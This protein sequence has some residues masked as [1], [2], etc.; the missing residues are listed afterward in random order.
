MPATDRSV[1]IAVPRETVPG[2]NRVALV[3]GS[4]R[5]LVRAG[6]EV[7]VQTGA[8]DR[9]YFQD[10][11]YEEAGARLMEEAGPL[12]GEADVVLKI[13]APTVTGGRHDRGGGR[14]AASSQ[15]LSGNVPPSGGVSVS[16]S[17]EA[18]LLKEGAVLVSFLYPDQ[19]PALVQK[20]LQKRVTAFAM[21]RIPRISRAQRMD[22]L[23]SQ[24]TVAGYL[25][26]LLAASHSPR[27]FPLLMTAAG[28]FPP[29][30]V[31]VVGA[32]VAG[33]QAIA[34]ARRLGARVEAFDVRPEV[35]EQVESLGAAFVGT[36]LEEARGVGGYA[37]ELSEEAHRKERA[38]LKTHLRQA[39]VVITTALVP[40]KKAPVLVTSEM[41]AGMKRGC[42]LVDLAAEQGGNCELTRAGETVVLP[43]GVQ[44]LGPVNLPAR[45]PLAASSMY[46][47]NITSFFLALTDTGRLRFD[48]EDELLKATC[49]THRGERR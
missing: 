25:S 4:V 31:L 42:V 26:V 7:R 2:E 11:E 46:A 48:F 10:A 17:H 28:T 6:F 21:E 32:G 1:R 33:L 39:D 45:M 37:A 30:R 47:R 18:D 20:L 3:P 16:G 43:G 23:S 27:F 34:T 36:A 15:R 19:D 44:L 40:G 12:L 35:K 29:A 5:E 9:A 38:L 14:G 13:H 8:G 41:A 22:A 24:G 49:V